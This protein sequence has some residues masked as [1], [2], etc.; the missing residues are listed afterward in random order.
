MAGTKDVV[1]ADPGIDVTQ[2][3]EP[4]GERLVLLGTFDGGKVPVRGRVAHRLVPGEGPPIEHIVWPGVLLM[5]AHIGHMLTMGV[6]LFQLDAQSGDID[7]L[8][9]HR[10]LA[11]DL[12]VQMVVSEIPVAPG[13]DIPAVGVGLG[14]GLIQ[15]HTAFLCQP[16]VSVSVPIIEG[17][18][19]YDVSGVAQIPVFPFPL[20]LHRIV[21]LD[22]GEDQVIGVLE[23]NGIEKIGI[24]EGYIFHGF[25]LFDE[26]IAEPGKL[27]ELEPQEAEIVVGIDIRLGRADL[28]AVKNAV[29]GV[30]GGL[31][32]GP[33]RIRIGKIGDHPACRALIDIVGHVPVTGIWV[34]RTA[35]GIFVG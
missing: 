22:G 20:H 11:E 33:V 12:P 8:V 35:A 5:I 18:A 34:G 3:L 10:V 32:F 29:L 2:I 21:H 13:K 4:A 19:G 14:S 31:S 30:R 25:Q 6:D 16:E 1:A 17:A 23:S 26:K 15:I 28:A 24:A 27:V 7:D 9:A